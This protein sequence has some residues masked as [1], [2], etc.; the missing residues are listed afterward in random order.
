MFIISIA[1]VEVEFFLPLFPINYKNKIDKIVALFQDCL[2][3]EIYVCVKFLV[4]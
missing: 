1:F 4:I 2:I 3:S